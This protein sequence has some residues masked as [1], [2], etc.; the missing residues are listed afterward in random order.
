[1]R[2]VAL[3]FTA[4]LG[5]AFSSAEATHSSRVPCAEQDSTLCPLYRAAPGYS[6]HKLSHSRAH[7]L[8]AKSR[9]SGESAA[10]PA[11]DTR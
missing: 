1:M 8:G 4:L 2:R 5:F 9:N 6:G 3:A 11:K 7:R 10:K